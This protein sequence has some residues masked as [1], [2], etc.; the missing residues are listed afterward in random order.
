MNHQCPICASKGFVIHKN[1][2]DYYYGH[3]GQ[4]DF[5]RCDSGSC[6]LVWIHPMPKSGEILNF[7][8][9]YYTHSRRGIKSKL[10]FLV[11]KIIAPIIINV[12]Q[13]WR[14]CFVQAIEKVYPSLVTDALFGLGANSPFGSKSVLDI[15]CGNGERLSLFRH[16]GWLTT[17][18]IDSD[19]KAVDMARSLGRNVQ[20]GSMVSIP[21]ASDSF[22]FIFLHHVVEHVHDIKAG[23]SECFRVLRVGG[24]I[25]ILT[26]N[27]NSRLH[28]HY[29]KY[30][31]G[32]EAPR[33]LR[34]YTMAS[35]KQCLYEA[36]FVPQQLL[37]LDRSH[38]WISRQAEEVMSRL[39]ITSTRKEI[40]E[41]TASSGE[42]LLSIA[43]RPKHE[44]K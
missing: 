34:I 16:I 10:K 37:T 40:S 36:G 5:F 2:L 41:L 13:G 32:L 4:W 44:D 33:H 6:G 22:D 24:K 21:Y 7:Y 39:K 1:V 42:E 11:V 29:G 28:H 12:N 15:G 26:P 38:K 31:R 30:W 35:L 9:N 27:A 23:L 25:F 8:N 14:K 18:G 43:I 3:E 20:V 19:P 17:A